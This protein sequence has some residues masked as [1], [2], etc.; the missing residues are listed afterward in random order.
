MFYKRHAA[1]FY[2]SF[3]ILQNTYCTC[4]IML[5]TVYIVIKYTY[6][7]II[8]YH[9]HNSILWYVKVMSSIISWYIRILLYNR[10]ISEERGREI[11]QV[12]FIQGHDWSV[13]LKD[14]CVTFLTS[15]KNYYNTMYYTHYIRHSTNK[16]T[17]YLAAPPSPGHQHI[18]MTFKSPFNYYNWFVNYGLLYSHINH[19]DSISMIFSPEY[20]ILK[21]L[22]RSV[23]IK[24]VL[25]R[26]STC[27]C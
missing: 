11:I 26:N 16:T 9:V 2:F 5:S 8:I 13:G 7:C 10:A 14:N 18:T 27:A 3:I 6:K 4:I 23:P 22:H 12:K 19:Q 25:F 20:N 21:R 1:L 24:F 17:Y 15:H